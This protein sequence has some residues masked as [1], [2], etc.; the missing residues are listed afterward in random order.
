MNLKPL[1]TEDLE[2]KYRTTAT[3]TYILAGMLVALLAL[4][5]YLSLRDGFNALVVVPLA[6]STIVITN[7][8]TI[9]LMKAEL[10]ARKNSAINP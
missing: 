10:A 8:R 2:K 4:A 9:K 5:V 7:F 3:L 6:L 1:S